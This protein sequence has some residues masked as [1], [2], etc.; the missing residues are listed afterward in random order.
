[1]PTKWL[2]EPKIILRLGL[3]VLNF[4]LLCLTFDAHDKF[5]FFWHRIRSGARRAELGA[6]PLGPT[7][8]WLLAESFPLPLN[9]LCR[10]Q[11]IC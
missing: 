1:M 10:E 6:I 5:K 4:S 2:A 8:I 11:R 7:D 9:S 3:Q